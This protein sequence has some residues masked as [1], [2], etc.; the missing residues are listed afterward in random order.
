MSKSKAIKGLEIE[1]IKR[2][3]I[4][5]KPAKTSR[6]TLR[7]K[8]CY[9][10]KVTNSD[11]ITV[12][13]ECSL[14]PGLSHET[15]NDAVAELKRISEGTTLN[16]DDVP[17]ELPSVRFA[18]E[19]LIQKLNDYRPQTPFTKGENGLDINGLVWMA[20]AE[21]M[22]KQV[23]ELKSRGFKTIKLKIGALNFDE[24]IEV[25]KNVRLICPYP[26]YTIRLDANG[27][28]RDDAI[29]KLKM[30]TPFNIHSVEQPVAQGQLELLAQVC[31]QSPIKIAL[32]EELIGIFSTEEM[33]QVLDKSNPDYIIIKPSLLGGLENAEKWIS[34]AEQ[35]GI[36]WWSTSALESNI[37]LQVIAD[38]TS[39]M[40]SKR[41]LFEGVSGLGTGSLFE[42]NTGGELVVDNGQTFYTPHPTIEV[43]GRKWSLDI[44]GSNEFIDDDLRPKWS[45]GIADF[46]DFWFNTSYPLE[47]QTSGSTGLPKLISH[48]RDSVI[49]SATRTLEFFDLCKGARILHALPMHFI[50]G[51]MMLARGVIGRLNIIAIDPKINTSWF[52]P[53]DFTALTPHQLTKLHTPIEGKILLGGSPVP[54]TLSNNSGNIY[55]GYGM[56]ETLTHVAIKKVNDQT[57][58]AL[59]GVSFSVSNSGNLIISDPKRGF[60]NLETDDIVELHSSKSFSWVGRSSDIINSGGIKFNPIYLEAKLSNVLTSDYALYGIPHTELGTSIELRIDI[61]EPT[62]SQLNELVQKVSGKLKGVESPRSYK[63]GPIERNSAGKIL[64]KRM[65]Q[66]IPVIVFAT[67]NQNKVREVQKLLEGQYIV[68]SLPDIGCTDDIL[69]TA[70]TLEGNAVLKAKF[71]KENFGFDCFADDTGLEVKALDGA[72]GVITARYG[73]PKKNADKNM[74][75]LLSELNKVSSKDRSAQFRTAIYIITGKTEK[76]IEGVCT[77]TIALNQSGIEGFGYDPIFIPTGETRTFSEMTTEE[78]NK[79]SHRGIAIR[80]MLKYLSSLH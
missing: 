76:L 28:W 6:D 26:E 2:P 70:S 31:D 48:S 38:W 50:A 12:W 36:G 44:N 4:F 47:C 46:L 11:G 37:G 45:D 24:E 43:E 61:P 75:H 3:L 32:D 13:G 54:D 29:D 35:R 16:L 53:I 73:G 65:A 52:G 17:I 79:V 72:P 30:L 80:E 77:G 40:M 23:I 55:E 8:P 7:E 67:A 60:R 59:P 64:R 34:I 1:V 14:I 41:P 51:K 19:M 5:K 10:I 58:E 39:Q 15:E 69:E 74:A 57:F 33:E 42:N 68:K 71:V 9:L 18:V 21:G 56:T 25:L 66:N 27:A 63:F 22:L 78:K 49:Y 62:E 20:D